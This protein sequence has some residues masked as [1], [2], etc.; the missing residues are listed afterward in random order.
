M[1]PFTEFQKACPVGCR[2]SERPDPASRYKYYVCGKGC[3][4]GVLFEDSL[5]VYIEWLMEDGRLVA[6]P[7]EIRYKAWPKWEFARLVREGVWE[8]TTELALAA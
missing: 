3:T 2:L 8:P 7:P 6:Y 4:L 5:N 1:C